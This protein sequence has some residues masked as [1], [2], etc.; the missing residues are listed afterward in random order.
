MAAEHSTRIQP[1][2]ANPPGLG[3][4]VAQFACINSVTMDILEQVLYYLK[5]TLFDYCWG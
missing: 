2:L 3:S 5:R 1:N 4:W